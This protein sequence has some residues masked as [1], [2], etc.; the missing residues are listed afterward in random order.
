MECRVLSC[1]GA[2]GRHAKTKKVIIWRVFAWR[3]FAF[4]PLF[5]V[6]LLGGAKGRRAKT[7]HSDFGGFSRGDL[8]SRQAKIRQKGGEKATHEKCRTFVL[9]GER[10]PCENTK[11]SPFGG[12]SRGA[13]S[14]FRPENTIIRHGTNQPPYFRKKT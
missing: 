12:F 10:S 3:P 4:S 9:R 1:G 13:I 6:S 7:R 5:V 2:K 14:P 11:K 8:S